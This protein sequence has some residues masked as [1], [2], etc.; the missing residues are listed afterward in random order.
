VDSPIVLEQYPLLYKLTV[1]SALISSVLNT[2]MLII[3]LGIE[4]VESRLQRRAREVDIE[5]EKI[6]HEVDQ[7]IYRKAEDIVMKKENRTK[8]TLSPGLNSVSLGFAE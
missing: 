6:N 2:T 7:E 5:K 4:D 8:C 1:G 3:D